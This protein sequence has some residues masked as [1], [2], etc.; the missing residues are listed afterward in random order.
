MYHMLMNLYKTKN[1]HLLH[2][3]TCVYTVLHDYSTYTY[4]CVC[5]CW[6]LLSNWCT[7]MKYTCY[8]IR[9]CMQLFLYGKLLS[10]VLWLF[11]VSSS[12]M[13]ATYSNF[14]QNH[15]QHID[16]KAF[17][18]AG[19]VHTVL[20]TCCNYCVYAIDVCIYAWICCKLLSK[21]EYGST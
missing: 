4:M 15:L 20:C 13:T 10:S 9:R 5:I 16:K 6:K 2:C 1:V 7:I 12:H 14:Q 19:W 3:T 8:I 18:L 11:V 17:T 21:H